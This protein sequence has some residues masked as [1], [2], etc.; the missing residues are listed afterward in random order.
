MP[1]VPKYLDLPSEKWKWKSLNHV[2]FLQQINKNEL[3]FLKKSSHEK[4][5]RTVGGRLKGLKKYF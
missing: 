4:A 5:I 1:V 2:W 3:K